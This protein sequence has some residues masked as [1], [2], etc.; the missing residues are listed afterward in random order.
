MNS[1]T[2][3]WVFPSPSPATSLRNSLVV[4][5]SMRVFDTFKSPGR[6][7]IRSPQTGPRDRTNGHR[8]FEAVGT[9]HDGVVNVSP[10]ADV[11][12]S[13]M[14]TYLAI[15]SCVYVRMCVCVRVFGCVK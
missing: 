14:G 5:P 1:K 7:V 3:F 13:S 11:T 15:W 8:L 4:L 2:G 10:A 6:T 12:I 9:Q